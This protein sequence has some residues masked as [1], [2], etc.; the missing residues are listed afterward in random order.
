MTTSGLNCSRRPETVRSYSPN[1]SCRRLHQWSLVTEVSSVSLRGVV[2]E[3]DQAR[4]TFELQPVYGPKV[5]GP[6]PREYLET[7]MGAFNRY[8]FGEKIIVQGTGAV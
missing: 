6:I 8:A 5:S 7:V 3:A 2:S 4:M 1:R